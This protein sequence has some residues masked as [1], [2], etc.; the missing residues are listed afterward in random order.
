MRSFYIGRSQILR[1]LRGIA[2]SA[3]NAWAFSISS[4]FWALFDLLTMFTTVK[5]YYFIKK[6]G[7]FKNPMGFSPLIPGTDFFETGNACLGFFNPKQ[8]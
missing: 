8:D 6:F 5:K 2:K 7:W 3:R 1:P 4:K